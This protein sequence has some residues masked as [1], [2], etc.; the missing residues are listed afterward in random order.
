MWIHAVNPDS[1]FI[2]R[3]K[4]FCVLWL[5]VGMAYKKHELVLQ[6]H[7]SGSSFL[8]CCSGARTQNVAALSGNSIAT[9]FFETKDY[10]KPS[11]KL[12]VRSFVHASS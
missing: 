10:K 11:L 6:R 3:K 9:L 5:C 8:F 2:W 7:K 4:N 12:D 1:Y